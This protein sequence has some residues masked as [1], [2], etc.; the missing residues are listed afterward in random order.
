MNVPKDS[1]RKKM[2][3]KKEKDNLNKLKSLCQFGCVTDWNYLCS[4]M[5]LAY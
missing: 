3:P 2:Y 1:S 4:C 5:L